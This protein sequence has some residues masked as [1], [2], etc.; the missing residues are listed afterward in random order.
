MI[1]VLFKPNRYIISSPYAVVYG[2]SSA[3]LADRL[4]SDEKVRVDEQVTRLGQEGLAKATEELKIAQAHNDRPI[5]LEL[6]T[7]FP[8][9]DV[10]GISWIP[11]QSVQNAGREGQKA[12]PIV[13]SEELAKH[14]A[15]DSSD[16]PF[17]VQYDHVKVRLPE[18]SRVVLSV[19]E[20]A[21]SPTL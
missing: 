11:V 14:I 7:C 8:L 13:G 10:R 12:T 3:A 16:L 9:P 18:D 20:I 4:E 5:P 21:G 1:G 19:D 6:L 15:E 2:R 17:F